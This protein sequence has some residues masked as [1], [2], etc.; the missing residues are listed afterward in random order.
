VRPS[1]RCNGRDEAGGEAEGVKARSRGK[2]G[3]GE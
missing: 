1:R 3:G 2:I